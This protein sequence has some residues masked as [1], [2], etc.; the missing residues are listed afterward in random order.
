MPADLAYLQLGL[1]FNF[2][3]YFWKNQTMQH[4]NSV[5]HWLSV[6]SI[7]KKKIYQFSHLDTLCF[8]CECGDQWYSSQQQQ[9]PFYMSAYVSQHIQ[10]R[11][12]GFC[13]SSFTAHVPLLTVTSTFGLGRQR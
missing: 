11:T 2:F 3:Y 7:Q 9:E 1:G 12:G 10:L 5:L 6:T 4:F 13:W 8:V